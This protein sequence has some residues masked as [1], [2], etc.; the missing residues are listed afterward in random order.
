MSQLS[1]DVAA[2]TTAVEKIQTTIQ[3]LQAKATAPSADAPA[4]SD[5][6]AITNATATLNSLAN[7][8]P[9]PPAA[10]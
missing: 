2:L 5:L 6:D 4:Q 7:A 3:N 9:G 8:D 1:D 10:A